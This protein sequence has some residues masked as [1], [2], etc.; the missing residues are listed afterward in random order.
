MSDVSKREGVFDYVVVGAGPAG[1]QL[2]YFLKK[3][4]RSFVILEAGESAGTFFR[5]FPRHRKLISI[6]K[7][8]TGYDDPEINLRWD[9]NS[10]LG[11]ERVPLF[12]HYSREYFPQADLLVDYLRDYAR[13]YELPVETGVN[14][15]R[16]SKHDG[17]FSAADDQGRSWS[18]RCLV[19]ATG[20][21]RAHVPPVPGIELSENYVDVSVDPEQFIGKRVLILGKG[22]SALETADNLIPT[23]ALIHI[24]SPHPIKMAWKT[25]H[26]GHLRA[27]NNNFLDTYQL[28][29]QNAVLDCEVKRIEMKDGVYHVTVAYTHADGEAEVLEYDRVIACTGFAFDASIFAPE[30]RPKLA[31]FDR[32]PDLTNAWES[33]SVPGLY[34]AGT[35]MQMRDFK[36]YTSGF[37]HGFR[38]NVRALHN[39]LELRQHGRPWPNR[40]LN[41]SEIT[42][43]VIARVNR[44]SAMWQQFSV[45]GDVIVVEDGGARARHY[46]EL[47]LDYAREWLADCPHY[48]T[49]NLE[50]GKTDG[51]PFNVMRHPDPMRAQESFFLHPAV[52]HYSCGQLQ[53][54]H[55]LLEDLSGEWK[56]EQQHIAPLRA[57]F[58]RSLGMPQGSVAGVACG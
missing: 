58:E 34:F 9:W 27:V 56:R 46:E 54:E 43:A 52:R 50:F 53:A 32:F 20:L 35:L 10:L 36:K 41:V 24:A 48:Y 16:V 22:N 33:V 8:H 23:A 17:V 29:S 51:D 15:T 31:I 14:V 4:G 18:A 49:V 30:C 25:H 12:K 39:I 6:N 21:T 5:K 47:P 26:V 40:T 57:F 13:V 37:I 42:A 7:V 3:A 1:L 11:D 44:T 2:G 55:H 19:I 38:Y 45:L 28:K